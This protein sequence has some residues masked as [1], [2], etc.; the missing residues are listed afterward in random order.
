MKTEV[1]LGALTLATLLNGNVWAEGKFNLEELSFT[2]TGVATIQGISVKADDLIK[3]M[4]DDVNNTKSCP[5]NVN[6]PK[7]LAKPMI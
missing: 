5:T 1:A 4:K 2:D 7:C 6:C 3:R